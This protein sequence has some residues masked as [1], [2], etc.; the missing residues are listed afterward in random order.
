MTS[1]ELK[2]VGFAYPSRPTQRVIHSLNA[3]IGRGEIAC[4]VGPSGSGKS[5]ILSLLA[6]LNLPPEGEIQ[7]GGRAVSGPGTDRSIVFQRDSLFPWMTAMGNVAF[8]IRQSN[9]ALARAE[10]RDLAEQWLRRVSLW[11]ARDKYPYQLSGGMQQRVALVRALA[12]DVE[13]LLL[14]EPFAALDV[15]MRAE[16][17]DLLLALIQDHPEKTAVFV[18]HDV[19]EAMY[20]ADRILVVEEGRLCGALEIP[21]PR[22]RARDMQDASAPQQMLRRRIVTLL[23][24]GMREGS[25]E[26]S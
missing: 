25:N 20:L 8:A 9:R 14:D 23:H 5:T 15:K 16:L 11:D 24:E 12:M 3:Q 17:Q 1:I 13:V 26:A 19:D 2:D 18:T 6:G 7:I 22:P 21:I 4:I 10:A